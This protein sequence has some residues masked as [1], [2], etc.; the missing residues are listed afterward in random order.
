MLGKKYS[1]ISRCMLKGR[2]VDGGILF[3]T[4]TKMMMRHHPV[5]VQHGH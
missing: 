3:E 1:Q 5:F 4:T 2:W